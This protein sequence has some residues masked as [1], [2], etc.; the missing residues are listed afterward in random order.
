MVE[1]SNGQET[2]KKDIQVRFTVGLTGYLYLIE[3][4]ELPYP[5]YASLCRR[6]QKVPITCGISDKTIELMKQKS[7]CLNEP[8]RLCILSLDEMEVIEKK[9][10]DKGSHAV[11]GNITLGNTNVMA[12]KLLLLVVRGQ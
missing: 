9:E 6:I 8:S 3:N 4:E 1:L 12:N 10:Y 2:I 5:S 7:I 11:V